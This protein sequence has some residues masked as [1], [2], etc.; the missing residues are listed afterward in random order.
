MFSAISKNLFSWEFKDEWL[1]VN[2]SRNFRTR[3]QLRPPIAVE[4]GSFYLFKAQKFQQEKTRFCGVT[5]PAFTKSWS[6]FDID[7]KEDLQLCRDLSSVL[8]FPPYLV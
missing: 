1:P 6:D 4:T 2:H 8:D 3:R 7:S 5:I